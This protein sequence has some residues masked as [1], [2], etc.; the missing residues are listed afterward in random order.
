M[1]GHAEKKLKKAAESGRLRYASIGI[2]AWL[3]LLIGSYIREELSVVSLALFAAV[4]ALSIYMIDTAL[5]MGTGFD[6]W[7]DL[8]IVTVIAESLGALFSAGTYV[9]AIAPL[10]VLWIAVKAGLEYMQ[11]TTKRPAT[12]QSVEMKRAKPNRKQN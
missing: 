2:G 5:S 11:S 8:F 10:Y 7:Q 9:F 4:T 3:S 12:N 6:I 1:A